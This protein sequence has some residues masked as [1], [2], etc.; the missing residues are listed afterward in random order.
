M[1]IPLLLLLAN[2]GVS[3]KA[4]D[5]LKRSNPMPKSYPT[6][7]LVTIQKDYFGDSDYKMFSKDKSLQEE[8]ELSGARFK[9]NAIIPVYSKNRLTLTAGVL[10]T[11]QSIVH[12]KKLGSSDD[13]YQK[14]ETTKND[15]D[16][17]FSMMYVG[18][19]W[20]K[21]IIHNATLVLGSTNFFG[22]KK[23]S[24]LLSSSLMLKRDLTTMSM[25]GLAV[26]LDKSSLFPV[27]PVYS[28]WHKFSNSEWEIDA[29][30]PQKVLL[31]RSNVLNGWLT[32]GSE[33]RND[34]FFLKQ[35]AEGSYRSG[36]YEWSSNEIFSSV[37]YEYLLGK[38]FLLGIKGG[39]RNSLTTRLIKVNEN[40]NHYKSRT[41]V[42]STFFNMNM[43]FV[44]PTPGLKDAARA[45][46]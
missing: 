13:H 44:L 41:S 21:P 15:F 28:Y 24:G 46:K 33:I 25:I 34:S 26:T 35:E 43:S 40:F 20:N 22:I 19:L 2:I 18:R 17:L 29:V 1:K 9:I 4:Q 10:Y 39:Y 7:K 36:N 16:A 37:G 12:Y 45:K 11:N 38:N 32:I 3:A 6:I 23:M 31:R 14:Q 8:G 27:I 5:T 42:A 30:L